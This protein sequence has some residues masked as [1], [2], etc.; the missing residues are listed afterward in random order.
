[1]LVDPE[2]T[3][4]QYNYSSN[5]LVLVLETPTQQTDDK[6]ANERKIRRTLQRQLQAK[7]D[8][9]EALKEQNKI[10]Q[11][12]YQKQLQQLYAE[13]E[14]NEKL[15]SDMAERYAQL[16]F[17]QMD[18]F[19]LRISDCILN[20]RLTEADSLLRTKGDI[21]TRIANLQREETALAA[22]EA[23]LAQRQ[24]NLEKGK[25]VTQATKEDIAQDCFYRYELFLMNHQNDSAAHYLELRASLDT[26]N[27][28]WLN[29]AGLFL[30]DYLANY[31]LSLNYYQ[32]G[33]KQSIEQYG[34]DNEWSATF[35][36]N[37][38]LVYLELDN[39]EKAL[40][41][42]LKALP[43]FDAVHDN[44]HLSATALTYSNIGR[45]F[46]QQGNYNKALEYQLKTA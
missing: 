3:A 44:D 34:E 13:E 26:T 28:E 1:M 22:E 18:E 20:G 2:V 46:H 9:I 14:K 37:I 24:Q 43:I 6:L 40:D 10:T 31:Q 23:E 33:L 11:E 5:P 15:I 36:N 25:A 8:E 45:I 32:R 7:E 4:K 21:N 17:D 42:F 35:F 41:Y 38:G 16:D 19:N 29:K 39:N 12:E 30:F 27:V